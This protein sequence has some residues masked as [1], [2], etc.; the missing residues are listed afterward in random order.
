MINQSVFETGSCYDIQAYLE[1]HLLLRPQ[2]PECQEGRCVLLRPVW[3]LLHASVHTEL[4]QQT[5]LPVSPQCVDV[6][7][8]TSNHYQGRQQLPM[9]SMKPS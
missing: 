1:E 9:P 6:N 3:S 4:L 5:L 8:K 7:N 2:L